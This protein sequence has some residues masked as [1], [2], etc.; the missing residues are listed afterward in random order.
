MW[1]KV[2]DTEKREKGGPDRGKQ[3]AM[4]GRGPGIRGLMRPKADEERRG[5]RSGEGC[6][7][8]DFLRSREWP[9]MT[10]GMHGGREGSKGHRSQAH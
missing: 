4:A 5:E 10:M 1:V 2:G 9:V 6:V 8:T 7:W 3:T